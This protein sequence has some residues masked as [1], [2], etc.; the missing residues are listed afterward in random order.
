MGRVGGVSANPMTGLGDVLYGGG[1]SITGQVNV[2][3]PALGVT[4]TG[5][6][7]GTSPFGTGFANAIDGS[8]ATAA[9]MGNGGADK[10]WV[11]DLQS[12]KRI[13]AYRV[14]Q[15]ANAAEREPAVQL[16]SGSVGGGWSDP[17][18]RR[19]SSLVATFLDSGIITL[20]APITARWWRLTNIGGGANWDWGLAEIEL[21][22]VTTVGAGNQL[23]L[24]PPAERRIFAFE[25]DAGV[26]EW[27]AR[28]AAEADV[29]ALAA[30][31]AGAPAAYV[32]VDVANAGPAQVALLSELN[33]LRAV[34]VALTTDRDN[35]RTAVAALVTK[36]NAI[37]A[38]LEAA[39]VLAA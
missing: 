34:V 28:Q 31:V 12:A 13:G 17:F 16:D 7:A 8:N 10:R 6:R 24:A 15:S 36:L 3:T 5:Q 33:D 23:R 39:A 27:Q 30:A 1:G 19:D 4:V 18:T 32:G 21:F 38:K 20:P 9:L 22:E 35:E 26:P 29:A 25:P 2:A 37:I 14:V 11:V